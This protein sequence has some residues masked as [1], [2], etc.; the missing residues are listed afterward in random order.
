MCV[1]V[2]GGVRS[3]G[4]HTAQAGSHRQRRGCTAACCG[5]GGGLTLLCLGWRGG[6]GARGRGDVRYEPYSPKPDD[7]YYLGLGKEK[8]LKTKWDMLGDSILNNCTHKTP[9]TGF[10]E[11]TWN[12][13]EQAVPVMRYSQGN[14]KANGNGFMCSPYSPESGVRTFTG[15]R[16]A[17][18]VLRVLEVIGNKAAARPR[19]LAAAGAL[20]SAVCCVLC[21]H[22]RHHAWA[23]RGGGRFFSLSTSNL[24]THTRERDREG[25][26]G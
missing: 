16:S 15:S 6:A 3:T 4:W 26:R 2:P 14:K 18:C 12:R 22:R 13:V 21:A 9:T 7:A 11:P 23:L 10:C 17:R 19:V 8:V 1:L 20:A 5:Y 25:V 24:Y